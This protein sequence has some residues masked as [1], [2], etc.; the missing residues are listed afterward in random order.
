MLVGSPQLSV[1][2]THVQQ[3]HSPAMSQMP[4]HSFLEGTQNKC[5]IRND[6]EGLIYKRK[7][8]DLSYDRKD[9]PHAHGKWRPTGPRRGC[10][11]VYTGA[12]SIH[13]LCFAS[14]KLCPT[15]LATQHGQWPKVFLGASTATDKLEHPRVLKALKATRLEY[16]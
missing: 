13:T 6:A 3:G 2:C 9:P 1:K 11:F 5:R 4:P 10:R 12:A 15:T 7:K 8:N 14:Q 16:A